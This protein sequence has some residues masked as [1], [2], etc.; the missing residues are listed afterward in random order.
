MTCANL[1]YLEIIA[2]FLINVGRRITI[3]E[4]V[5]LEGQGSGCGSH[6]DTEDDGVSHQ[7]HLA[8]TGRSPLLLWLCF[9]FR[10]SP[11]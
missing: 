4:E 9:S 1:V 11:E 7:G 8:Q 10:F 3:V 5:L 6:L 2:P